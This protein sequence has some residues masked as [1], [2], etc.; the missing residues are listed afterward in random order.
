[1]QEVFESGDDSIFAPGVCSI[2]ISQQPAHACTVEL[3]WNE[4]TRR[5][6][7]LNRPMFYSDVSCWL[8]QYIY[9]INGANFMREV[10]QTFDDS[11]FARGCTAAIVFSTFSCVKP[12]NQ[13]YDIGFTSWLAYSTAHLQ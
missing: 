7:I 10:P 6:K 3:S 13:N 5:R 9:L 2:I 8:N 1:M 4:H 11:M 12:E